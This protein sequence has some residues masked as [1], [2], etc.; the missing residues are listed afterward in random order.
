MNVSSLSSAGYQPE[1]DNS[2]KHPLQNSQNTISYLD[3][4]RNS[5]VWRK[6]DPFLLVD[7]RPCPVRVSLAERP[8]AAVREAVI[9]SQTPCGYGNGNVNS[10]AHE[11]VSVHG[12]F[13]QVSSS[14]HFFCVVRSSMRHLSPNTSLFTSQSALTSST[15]SSWTK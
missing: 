6:L 3:Y 1:A 5:I 8:T 13:T 2:Q 12:V 11:C 14:G 4:K 10:A 15:F 7:E 9:S